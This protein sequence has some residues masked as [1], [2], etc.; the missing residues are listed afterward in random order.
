[1]QTYIRSIKQN[2]QVAWCNKAF[3]GILF[4]EII[5]LI[6]VIFFTYYFFDYIENRTGGVI[7]NDWVLK[8]IPAKDV[9][10]PIVLFEAR[11]MWGL[12]GYLMR[13]Y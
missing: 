6:F 9:S 3:R 12:V 11:G 8:M 4:L 7:M 2:W 13:E 5:A 1:M 10:I